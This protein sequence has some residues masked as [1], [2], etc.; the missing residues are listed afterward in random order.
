MALPM[1][2]PAT[3]AMP[4]TPERAPITLARVFG[5]KTTAAM[6]IPT[7]KNPPLPSPW[8]A[9]KTMS[10]VR[11]W[12]SPER[13]EPTMNTTRAPR[14][15]FRLLQMSESLAK[16]GM[17]AVEV[18]TYA[19][20]TK[21]PLLGVPN[22][23]R[24]VGSAVSATKLSSAPI[25]RASR[26]PTVIRSSNSTFGV[27]GASTTAGGSEGVLESERPANDG[28]ISPSPSCRR[29]WKAGRSRG[30]TS[31]ASLPKKDSWSSSP[32]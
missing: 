2:G 32:P 10:S 16:I 17:P 29:R 4:N 28:R 24:M 7:G 14:K 26:I 11:F 31:P 21:V 27:T 22:W 19:L 25:S 30:A 15:T 3:T 5:G 23:R 20:M 12:L 13:T 6:A 8:M 9:R 18:M 1:S